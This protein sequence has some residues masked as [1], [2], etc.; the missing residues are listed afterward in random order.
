M[1]NSLRFGFLGDIEG[2]GSAV[3]IAAL[4]ALAKRRMASGEASLELCA[5]GVPM[6]QPPLVSP[7]PGRNSEVAA[8]RQAPDSKEQNA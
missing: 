1:K 5:R 8:L 4:P 7:H 6:V 2:A 3:A